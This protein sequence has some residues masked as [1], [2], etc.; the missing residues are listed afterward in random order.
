MTAIISCGNRYEE[1]FQVIRIHASLSCLRAFMGTVIYG[2][3]D[4]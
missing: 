2:F 3:N 4:R 1:R